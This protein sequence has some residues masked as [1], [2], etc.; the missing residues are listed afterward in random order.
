MDAG[1][2][3]V[4]FAAMHPER[5]RALILGN[6]SAR[7]LIDEDY[8]IGLPTD[9]VDAMVETVEKLWGSTRLIRM[10]LPSRADDDEFVRWAAK[11]R[12]ASATPATAAVQHRYMWESV[13]VRSAL[14]LLQLPTLV[15]HN[16]GNRLV[17]I[18]HGRFLA[19]HIDGASHVEY[20][21]DD[22]FFYA[23]DPQPVIED[24]A[25]FVTGRSPNIDI[26]RVLTTVLFTDIV[27]ST[28]HAAAVGDHRWSDLLDSHEAITRTVVDQHQGRLINLTGDG[29]L[30]IFDSPGRA[31][32]SARALRD[33]LRPLGITIRAG[34]HT[35]EVER[36]GHD[37]AGI[38]VHVAARVVSH[39]APDEV[40]TSAALPLLVAGSGI[41]FMDRGDHELKGLPGSWRLFAVM[42]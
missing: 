18:E 2:I 11:V 10:S 30:A 16:R 4:L 14:P 38:G 1:P 25:R 5:T 22:A 27:G 28:E 26:D 17:P 6:T 23:G 39:A 13:D 34:L 7:T 32:R 20:D 31:I 12:R 9:V 37:I 24:I 29:V 15:L 36:R 41:E 40:L 42:P 8:P 19:Q 3:C 21:S 33:A 35:G